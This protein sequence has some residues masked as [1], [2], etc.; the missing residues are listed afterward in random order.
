MPETLEVAELL[1]AEL[2][3]TLGRMKHPV[4]QAELRRRLDL[5]E[6]AWPQLAG[7]VN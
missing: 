6:D 3:N 7:K 2:L 4:T 1:H 5:L